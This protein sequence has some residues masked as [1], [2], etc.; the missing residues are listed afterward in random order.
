MK[1]KSRRRMHHMHPEVQ[2]IIDYEFIN[3]DIDNYVKLDILF[4]ELD[5][6]EK[7]LEASGTPYVFIDP[8]EAA[9]SVENGRRRFEGYRDWIT[10]K[11]SENRADLPVPEEFDKLD[12]LYNSLVDVLWRDD[13]H[14][15]VILTLAQIVI[16]RGLDAYCEQN[17]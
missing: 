17:N 7:T 1:A 4:Y 2:D 15:T 12:D 10:E 9:I 14:A 16:V 8:E 5:R 11:I 6:V 3:Q 13:L